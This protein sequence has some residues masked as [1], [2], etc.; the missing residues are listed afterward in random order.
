M[1]N[2]LGFLVG[3]SVVAI[4]VACGGSSEPV[5]SADAGGGDG[6]GGD[7]GTNDTGSSVDKD[8]GTPPTVSVDFKATC[9]AFTPCGGDPTGI[10]HYTT[11][12]IDDATFAKVKQACPSA[13]FTNTSATIAGS[14][15][16][17]SANVVRDTTTHFKTTANVPQACASL[18]GGCAGVQAAL[19]NAYPSVKCV[20]ATAGA[21]TCTVDETTPL[22]QTG[23]YTIAGNVITTGGNLKYDFC[24]T[25]TKLEHK[26]NGNTQ[27]AEPGTFSLTKQ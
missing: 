26:A 4:A 17:T 3:L 27:T 11:G 12:C 2:K 20:D 23:T 1:N 22:K 14:L 19:G 15:T 7:S 25:G 21:C 5:T 10:W 6:A 18:A 9:S 8:A 24:V 13:T 16:F